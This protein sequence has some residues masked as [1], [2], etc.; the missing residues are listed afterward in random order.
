MSTEHITRQLR[1]VQGRLSDQLST[2]PVSVKDLIEVCRIVQELAQHVQRECE[3]DN[4]R[5][6]FRF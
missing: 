6:R 5:P 2:A 1:V 3:N 4:V